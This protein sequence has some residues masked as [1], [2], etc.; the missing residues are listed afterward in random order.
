[1]PGARCVPDRPLPVSAATRL[2]TVSPPTTTAATVTAR[3][4]SPSRSGISC[5]LAS[6]FFSSERDTRTSPGAAARARLR[7]LLDIER[8]LEHRSRGA[9]VRRVANRAH[10]DRAPRPGLHHLE[11]VPLVD[12]TDREPRLGRALRGVADVVDP[13]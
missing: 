7:A 8:R 9:G 13:G 2:A 3:G 6:A 10:D 4:R 12:A 1:M 5:A 11:D